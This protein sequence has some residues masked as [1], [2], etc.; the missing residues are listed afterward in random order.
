MKALNFEARGLFKR[1]AVAFA[2]AALLG[3]GGTA[4]ADEVADLKAEVRELAAQLQ[5]LKESI[6]SRQASPRLAP[7]GTYGG[8]GIA[9]PIPPSDS[10]GAQAVRNDPMAPSPQPAEVHAPAFTSVANPNPSPITSD[11]PTWK[12]GRTDVY[13][14]GRISEAYYHNGTTRPAVDGIVRTGLDGNNLSLAA[15]RN[16]DPGYYTSF[17]IN[18]RPDMTNGGIVSNGGIN[19][20]FAE[21]T[22]FNIGTPYGEFAIGRFNDGSFNVISMGDMYQPNG[23]GTKVVGT[24]NDYPSRENGMLQYTAPAFHGLVVSATVADGMQQ[25]TKNQLLETGVSVAYTDGPFAI[26]AT[27]QHNGPTGSGTV[28]LSHR[29]ICSVASHYYFPWLRL[30]GVYTHINAYAPGVT[31]SDRESIGLRAPLPFNRKFEAKFGW[32][33]QKSDG[34][35]AVDWRAGGVDYLWNDAT[36]FSLEAGKQSSDNLKNNDATMSY[37]FNVGYRW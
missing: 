1:R 8:P 36:T 26:G 33:H 27:C 29:K 37:I 28:F 30:G 3:A 35:K 16:W 31:A 13:I 22:R 18:L 14:W 9:P 23:L 12:L 34:A 4:H 10:A 6:N 24:L 2:A 25:A 7:P 19:S 20:P 32:D 17:Y 21:Q 15:N 5:A 11:R